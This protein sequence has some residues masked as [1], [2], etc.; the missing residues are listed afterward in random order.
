MTKSLTQIIAEIRI[1]AAVTE[2]LLN[3]QPLANLMT[4]WADNLEKLADMIERL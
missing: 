2:K 4:N 3:N 1:Q